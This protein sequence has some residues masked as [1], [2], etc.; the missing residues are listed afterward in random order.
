MALVAGAAALS[1]LGRTREAMA[2][3]RRAV[4]LARTLAD[5]ALFLHPTV[6]L[7]DQA[8]GDPTLLAEA[9]QTAHRLADALPDQTRL[10]RFQE[11]APVHRFFADA[12]SPSPATEWAGRAMSAYPD[13]LS[14]REVEVLRLIAV[15]KSNPEIALALV[16]SINTVERHV[17]HILQKT[18]AA[19][20][21]EAA[22]YAQRH[23]LAG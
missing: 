19:N 4:E 5:P 7:L 3:L 21:T 2:R 11:A 6:A 22:V 1:G 10:L 12:R 14:E 23:G 17:T 15:G 13:H 18:G 8:G 16:L 20:R 9:T